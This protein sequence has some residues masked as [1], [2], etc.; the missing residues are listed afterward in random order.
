MTARTF[1]STPVIFYCA[2]AS[3]ATRKRSSVSS[4]TPVGREENAETKKNGHFLGGGRGSRHQV[5]DEQ[6]RSSL[7]TKQN[8]ESDEQGRFT[9]HRHSS[10]IMRHRGYR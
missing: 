2:D 10:R 9:I 5:D 7:Q 4:Y 3:C 1:L 6:Q 8:G